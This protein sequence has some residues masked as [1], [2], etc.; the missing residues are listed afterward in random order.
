MLVQE[1]RE[2]GPLG[3]D[4]LVIGGVDLAGHPRVDHVLHIEVERRAHEEARMVHF[5][6]IVLIAPGFGSH[7]ISF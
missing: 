3:G 6:C 1:S 7:A 5:F 4:K 2:V